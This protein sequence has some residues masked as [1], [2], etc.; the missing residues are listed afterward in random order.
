MARGGGVFKII[1]QKTIGSLSY[2]KKV[3]DEE[4]RSDANI[5]T[6]GIP[7]KIYPL[8]DEEYN[9][10]D[11]DERLRFEIP[12]IADNSNVNIHIQI[13]SDSDFNNVLWDIYS[14]QFLDR[15]EFWDGS[16]WQSWPADGVTDSYYGNSGRFRIQGLVDPEDIINRGRWYWRLR[17]VK[18]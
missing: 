15:W 13:A 6:I 14:W 9:L 12:A 16:S 3:N 2:I 7:Y 11:S 1:R 5:V 10:S 8:D 17:C 4:I 18:R